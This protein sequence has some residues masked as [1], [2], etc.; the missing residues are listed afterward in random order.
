M[1][2]ILVVD[3]YE[4]TRVLLEMILTGAGYQVLT[5]ADGRE[6]LA[7]AEVYRPD[8]VVMDL[9]MP[10]VDGFQATRQLKTHPATRDVPVIAYTARPIPLSRDE[11]ALF[12]AV[13]VKPC[14]PDA[15][16]N[17]LHELLPTT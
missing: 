3:D 4:D 11:N 8:A 5:A 16:L 15:L 14:S 17:V 10:G 2:R 9:F 12:D 6:A 7:T 1:S 13:C